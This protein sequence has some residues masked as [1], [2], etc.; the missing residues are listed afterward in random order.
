MEA[1]LHPYAQGA[2]VEYLSPFDKKTC[3]RNRILSSHPVMVINNS[4]GT[5]NSSIQ[6]MMLTSKA[7]SYF[8]YRLYLNSLDPKWRRFSVVCTTK[9][10]TIEKCHLRSVLGFA[11]S[12]FV[13]K[14]LN[15][16]LF[17]IGMSDEIPE[18]YKQCDLTMAYLNAGEAN[19][20]QNP[21]CFH[22]NNTGNVDAFGRLNIASDQRP[23]HPN[24]TGVRG[25]VPRAGVNYNEYDAY[26]YE[27]P[28]D[29]IEQIT[30]EDEAEDTNEAILPTP[31][32]SNDAI[33]P[34]P[35]PSNDAKADSTDFSDADN[36]I[37]D[38]SGERVEKP[39]DTDTQVEFGNAVDID[40]VSY[41][42]YSI[43]PLTPEAKDL[44]EA[45]DQRDREYTSKVTPNLIRQMD[46]M[47]EEDAFRVWTM[48]K[49]A[50]FLVNAN[51]ASSQ[52]M[53]NKMVMYSNHQVRVMK[54]KLIEGVLNK[55]I[56]LRFMSERW[57]LALRCMTLNDIYDIKMG[58]ATYFSYLQLF[59]IALS[60]SYIGKL[61][62]EGLL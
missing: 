47:T 30:H 18:Y 43:D 7:E 60:R 39:L 22:V 5:P 56:N 28:A 27:K 34:T 21:E 1:A 42:T 38:T 54:D 13:R 12:G 45:R 33:L 44:I 8:G 31:E 55:E 37:A 16:Y 2:I 3:Q 14:C 51:I 61:Q 48:E 46:N 59:D 15:A 53:A 36:K 9:V 35:E 41:P 24:P 29:V 50:A 19:I 62:E 10:F 25:I 11:S 40:S 26:Y 20:P 52:Y 58:V 17:E 23:L 32:P 4:T 6:C 57:C 49:G